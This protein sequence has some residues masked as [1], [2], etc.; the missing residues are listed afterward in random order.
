MKRAGSWYLDK[1]MKPQRVAT[2]DSI[3]ARLEAIYGRSPRSGDSR[4]YVCR[5][6]RLLCAKDD[7][8]PNGSLRRFSLLGREISK[9]GHR[10]A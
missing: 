1:V 7:G 3:E 10:R 2:R 9:L 8:R 6:G 5:P 4:A